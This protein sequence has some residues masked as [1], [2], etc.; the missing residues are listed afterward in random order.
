MRFK[1]SKTVFITKNEDGLDYCI[2]RIPCGDLNIID[3]FCFSFL[4]EIVKNRQFRN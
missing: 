2:G 4:F 3:I 1:K